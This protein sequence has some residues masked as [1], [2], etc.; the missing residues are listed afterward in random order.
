ML[1]FYRIRA[2]LGCTVFGLRVVGRS[3]LP[4]NLIGILKTE[5]MTRTPAKEQ[6]IW[7]TELLQK[8]NL[9]CRDC[10]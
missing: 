7:M 2:V 9:Q 4:K 1:N 10:T 6:R 8:A 5:T 3:V